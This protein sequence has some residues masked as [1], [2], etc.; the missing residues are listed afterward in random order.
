MSKQRKHQQR[1][2][3]FSCNLRQFLQMGRYL[4][5]VAAYCVLAHLLPAQAAGA[6]EEIEAE[7]IEIAGNSAIVMEA[8]TGSALYEKNAKEEHYP[9][10]ITKIMTA[11]LAIENSSLEEEVTFSSD[12]VYK[13]DGS[14]IARDV[15]ESMTMEECLYGLMLQSANECAYAI[16]EHVGGD[17]DTFIHMMNERAKELGCRS[18]H[19]N[20]PHGLPDT[21][22]YTC[23]YDMALISREALNSETFRKIAGTEEY[24]IPPTN[25]HKEETYLR[26]T[27]KML[28]NYQGS[29][30]LYDGCIGGKTGYTSA[31]KNTLVTFARREGMTLICVV[32]NEEKSKQYQDTTALLDYCF[33]NP[34][35]T[36]K[37][38]Q[39][40]EKEGE[41]ALEEDCAEGL[42]ENAD[43]IIRKANV[44]LIPLDDLQSLQK[45]NFIRQTRQKVILGILAAAVAVG[46]GMGIVRYSNGF[47]WL[48]HKRRYQEYYAFKTIGEPR[49]RGR[50]SWQRRGRRRGWRRR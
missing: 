40:A 26:N 48:R 42:S 47:Y 30:Y 23:A 4:L 10:S 13:T 27:H 32:L 34:A 37:Y 16:A 24:T 21:D 22:H 39:K 33:H 5:L 50:R 41:S 8:S 31:A 36:E 19:F 38:A 9:A 49:R 7:E 20:N 28:T 18:T 3:V 46:A 25:K 44:Q 1:S 35:F 12:A 15:G 2:R 29:E 6:A 11:L 14:G 17:Y 45:Q 43:E